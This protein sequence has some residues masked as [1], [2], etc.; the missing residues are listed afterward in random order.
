MDNTT[1]DIDPLEVKQVL[2]RLNKVV[3]KLPA[4][5]LVYSLP[6]PIA[7][8]LILRKKATPVATDLYPDLDISVDELIDADLTWDNIQ[9]A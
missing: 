5:D 2:V 8:A 3:G 7:L 6:E 1:F 9:A 4:G